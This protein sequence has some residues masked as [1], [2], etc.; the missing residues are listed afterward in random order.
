V[1]AVLPPT[2][3]QLKMFRRELWKEGR[4][5]E[6]IGGE[7]GARRL[8][9]S[10]QGNDEV[11]AEAHFLELV[12]RH[13]PE[14]APAVIDV[15]DTSIDLHYVEG[16][17]V[18][19]LL[20]LL[21]DLERTDPR[22]RTARERLV[23]RCAGSCARVQE[24]LSEDLRTSQRKP[25][26]YPVQRKLAALC[27]LFDSCLQLGLDLNAVEAEARAAENYLRSI[28]CPVPFRDAAAKNMVMEIPELWLGRCS[29]ADQR[30]FVREAVR[31]SSL[32]PLDRARIVHVDFSSCSELTVPEDDP[33]SLLIHESS[34]LGRLPA[35]EDL[36][37]QPLPSDPMRLA[38]G[39]LV[40]MYRLGGRRLS[41]RLVHRDGYRLRYADESIS[42]YFEALVEAGE[43][44]CPQMAAGFPMLLQAARA[45]LG[46]L[47]EGFE[48]E[49]DWFRDRYRPQLDHYY[50]DVFPY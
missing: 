50:R 5:L 26:Y 20:T 4:P 3:E 45:I 47:A 43:E 40:R 35:R 27:E 10:F 48:A 28:S 12:N 9:K 38:V 42:F 18:H 11:R 44:L 7:T 29:A 39:M 15:A 1:F 24:L 33:I 23:E 13:K 49:R 6:L 41:Y 8:R 19:T 31:G 17:R 25:M 14:L 34:W 36:C 22:A 16:T 46:R 21:K 30:D 37:W 2:D 32:S